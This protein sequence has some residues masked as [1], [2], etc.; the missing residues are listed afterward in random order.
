MI[1]IN[2]EEVY[3]KVYW[4][5][6]Y[7]MLQK[8]GFGHKWMDWVMRTVRG[9]KVAIITNNLTSGGSRLGGRT[10]QRPKRRTG[11]PTTAK[12]MVRACCE[13]SSWTHNSHCAGRCWG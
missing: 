13:T 8:K 4:L 1:K 9:G 10:G 7:Q 11:R 2:F 12:M 6:L 3:D 5:F